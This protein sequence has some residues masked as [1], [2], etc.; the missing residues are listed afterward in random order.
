MHRPKSIRVAS[1]ARLTGAY[2]ELRMAAEE[3]G[4]EMKDLTDFR[5]TYHF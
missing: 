3:F 4:A 5:A 2:S 1:K